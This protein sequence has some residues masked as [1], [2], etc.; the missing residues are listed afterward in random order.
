MAGYIFDDWIFAESP[1]VRSW[2]GL[3]TIWLSPAE[4]E[5]EGHYWPILYTTFWLEHKLWGLEPSVSHLINVLPYMANVLLLWYLL[6]RL[7]VSGAWAVAAVFAVHPMHVD[8]VAM[9]IGRK[10]LL[11]GLF[12]MAAVLCWM[13][14]IVGVEDRRPGPPLRCPGRPWLPDSLGVPRPGLYVAALGMFAAAMLS[15]S[16]AVTLPV[17]FAILL[18]WKNGRVTWSDASRIGPF[19]LVALCIALADLAYYTAE[20]DFRFGHGLFER[21]LLAARSLWFYA[22]K[23]VWPR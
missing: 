9:V 4:I 5:R 12:C 14:S 22:E 21:M 2:S 10:D 19:F 13:R 15:K 20:R 18:W 23:L 1:A 11:C 8:S 6:R 16:V 7:A 3:W 17:A